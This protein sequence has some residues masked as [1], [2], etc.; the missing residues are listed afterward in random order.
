MSILLKLDFYTTLNNAFD[1]AKDSVYS[2]TPVSVEIIPPLLL[3]FFGFI[4]GTLQI[5][6][7]SATT[8]RL[9]P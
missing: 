2:H 6:L 7:G 3:N 4:K 1:R 9:L 5:L 8:K